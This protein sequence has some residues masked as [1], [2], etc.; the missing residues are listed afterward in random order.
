LN[1]NLASAHYAL[2]TAYTWYDWDWV[3]AEKEFQRALALNPDDALGRNWYGGYLSLLG[4]HNEAI[5]QHER[6]RQLEPFSL[7]VNANLARALYWAR[8]YDEA[9][10]HARATLDLDP[11]F[12]VAL[13]WL[14]G[15]LRHKQMFREAIALRKAVFPKQAAA[16]EKQ[17]QTAGFQS[18][19]RRDGVDFKKD[20]DLI[21]AARC[22]AQVARKDEAIALLES[23][24][25]RRCS[26]M[27]TLKAE[28][29]FDVL[30]DEPRFQQLVQQMGLP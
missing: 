6:A 12:A 17:F 3:N 22:Y 27:V 16:L 14:E 24:L 1:D 20:G 23:C 5:D 25:R 13:F 30:R 26:S 11:K 10:A 9:I 2:A 18:V 8:R 29:D 21:Q 28:P 19:L 15:S 7:V 4:R